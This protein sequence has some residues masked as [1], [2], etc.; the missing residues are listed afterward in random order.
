MD[1]DWVPLK[2][3]PNLKEMTEA[4]IASTEPSVGWCLLCNR[5]I[6]SKNELIPQTNTHDCPEGRT[7]EESHKS[8]AAG[9]S[10]KGQPK[11]CGK[12]NK[13]KPVRPRGR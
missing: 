2:F 9:L 5:P 3:P 6:K 11:P 10:R 7:F 4:W 8:L 1:D 12:R 13:V